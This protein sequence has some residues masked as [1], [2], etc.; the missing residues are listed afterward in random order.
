MLGIQF[1]SKLYIELEEKTEN[2]C[3]KN[4]FRSSGLRD[5]CWA[6]KKLLKDQNDFNDQLDH[7]LTICSYHRDL[8]R[9]EMF[10]KQL[11]R[12]GCLRW[13]FNET[14]LLTKRVLGSGGFSIV[15]DGLLGNSDSLHFEMKEL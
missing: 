10:L 15:Y 14:Y 1:G 6:E 7:H 12:I 11:G 5:S 9:L 8:C 2:E 3:S 13:D 4:E